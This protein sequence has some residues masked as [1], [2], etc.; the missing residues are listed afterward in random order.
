MA[1][2]AVAAAPLRA[3]E[4]SAS[5]ELGATVLAE[6]N[7]G[8][9]Y[10]SK[11]G[12]VST[13]AVA[14]LT[15]LRRS[16]LM[17]VALAT[18]ASAR[19]YPDD[20]AL[21]REEY[22]VEGSLDL[23]GERSSW[24][25]LAR[26]TRESTLVTELGTTGLTDVNQLRRERFVSVSPVL[27][28]DERTSFQVGLQMQD[29]DYPERDSSALN[30]YRRDS[31]TLGIGRVLSENL[32]SNISISGAALHVDERGAGSRDQSANLALQWRVG[33]RSNLR[34]SGG[35]NR[36]ERAG[37]RRQGNVLGASVQRQFE[38]GSIALDANRGLEP[39][40]RG[41]ITESDT[42]RLSASWLP[43]ER[44]QL[45]STVSLRESRYLLQDFAFPLSKVRYAHA[46]LT[47]G[48]QLAR[49]WR[50]GWQVGHSWNRQSN[51]RTTATGFETRMTLSWSAPLHGR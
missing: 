37:A 6:E 23:Q 17:A 24:N 42:L 3:A 1:F 15:I 44:L 41:L 47:L 32:R 4:W 36:V 11:D 10:A 51:N 49:E 46:D 19:R 26:M 27:Q 14:G 5:T 35:I 30:D 7:P 25:A 16:E 28:L 13:E 40:G 21:D 12:A 38:R 31:V 18:H 9:S 22:R 33:T 34:L 2:L 29:I 48:W 45:G 20:D 8:L 43:R 50:L 39:V